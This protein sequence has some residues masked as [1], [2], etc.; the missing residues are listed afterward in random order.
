MIC[1]TSQIKTDGVYNL[2]LHKNSHF[3][4]YKPMYFNNLKSMVLTNNYESPKFSRNIHS[5]LAVQATNTAFEN[6]A[7]CQNADKKPHC[8][9]AR[10]FNKYFSTLSTF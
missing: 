1:H 7:H 10:D 3:Y 4:F 2:R 8:N 5:S 6:S 9:L